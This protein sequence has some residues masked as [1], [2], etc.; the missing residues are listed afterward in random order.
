[1]SLLTSES[2][3]VHVSKY[4][5]MNLYSQ[6]PL[7]GLYVYDYVYRGVMESRVSTV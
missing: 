1:M 7:N 3:F 2:L 5:R 6:M 4:S